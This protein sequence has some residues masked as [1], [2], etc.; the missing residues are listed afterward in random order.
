ML[1]A[2]LDF[3]CCECL[4]YYTFYLIV[5]NFHILTHNSNRTQGKSFHKEFSKFSSF[6]VHFL[7]F[8]FF[9]LSTFGLCTMCVCGK[10]ENSSL[11]VAAAQR[12]A[13]VTYKEHTPSGCVCLV[14][15]C[16]AED[17]GA[18]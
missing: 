14:Y 9:V 12:S 8:Y 7:F 10:C 6:L 11:C 3:D 2:I 13:P 16:F 4:H 15:L 5:E 17:D 1:Y 18:L